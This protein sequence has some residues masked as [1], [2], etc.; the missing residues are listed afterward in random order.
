[1]IREEFKKNLMAKAFDVFIREFTKNK[2]GVPY[3]F[4]ILEQK[5]I[6][7]LYVIYSLI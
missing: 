7:Q 3:N 6:S 4:N 5:K 2:E 1:V